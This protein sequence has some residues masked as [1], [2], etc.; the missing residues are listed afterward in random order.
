[1]FIGLF[2]KYCNIK[3]HENPSVDSRVVPCGQTDVTKLMVAF[4]KF[5][6]SAR[7][8]LIVSLLAAHNKFAMS[9]FHVR[10]TY[11]VLL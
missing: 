7:K 6:K 9:E 10:S 8:W 2:E 3:F 5:A 1:M 11:F 4:C